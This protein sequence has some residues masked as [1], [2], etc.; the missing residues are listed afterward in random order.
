MRYAKFVSDD[1]DEGC[2]IY[3]DNDPNDGP[4]I[5]FTWPEWHRL[6][7]E[8]QSLHTQAEVI[9]RRDQARRFDNVDT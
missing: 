4:I 1:P 7:F 5:S 8:I 3:N 6:I 9:E 2:G